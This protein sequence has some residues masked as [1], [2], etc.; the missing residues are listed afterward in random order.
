[1]NVYLSLK[2]Y[3]FILHGNHTEYTKN[4]ILYTCKINRYIYKFFRLTDTPKL[5]N[6]RS[7][8]N[9]VTLLFK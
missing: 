4:T 7:V 8:I 9:F 3:D 2:T 5:I 6:S 1:M